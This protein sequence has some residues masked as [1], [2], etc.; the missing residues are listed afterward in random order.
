[1]K[2]VARGSGPHSP[3]AVKNAEV[4]H[5]GF[6]RQT[7]LVVK[8][9]DGSVS[10]RVPRETSILERNVIALLSCAERP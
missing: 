10:R 8:G 4:A 7:L 5:N 9:R 2:I 3:V 1:M 6:N